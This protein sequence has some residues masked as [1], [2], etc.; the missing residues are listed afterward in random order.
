MVP[1][2]TYRIVKCFPYPIH[3]LEIGGA[4]TGADIL[5]DLLIVSIPILLLR[6]SQLLLGQKVRILVFLCL[7]IFMIAFAL[8][9]LIGSLYHDG[10]GVL[11][12]A[13]TWTHTWLHFESSVAVLM[14]GLTA[15]RIVFA[16]HVREAGKRK[17]MN[18]TSFYQRFKGFWIKTSKDS[19][20]L[21]NSEE[22]Q[23]GF[24]A[25]PATGGTLKGLRTF[26][27]KNGRGTGDTTIDAD[28][29]MLNSKYDPLESYHHYVKGAQSET[30]SRP[31]TEPRAS[32]EMQVCICSTIV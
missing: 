16:S 15:F 24:L 2:L 23:N 13:V 5:T 3:N 10:S 22:K 19:N 7:S 9:R 6:K 18:T 1:W 29:S 30:S 11:T 4:S 26:I 17:M 14:G 21:R 27:R 28:E 20:T 25:G 8:A 12:L 31:T 32:P